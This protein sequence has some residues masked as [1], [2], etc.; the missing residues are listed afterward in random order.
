MSYSAKVLKKDIKRLW[1]TLTKEIESGSCPD[2]G[3]CEE[4]L[5]KCDDYTL[6]SDHNWS[7]QWSQCCVSIKECITAAHKSDFA[8]AA[9]MIKEIKKMKKECHSKY[10][11]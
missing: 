3:S 10:K 4:L 8:E 9:R 2:R 6:F 11:K 1:K 7:D 5:K